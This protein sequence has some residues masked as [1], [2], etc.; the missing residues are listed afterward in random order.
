MGSGLAIRP[1]ATIGAIVVALVGATLWFL[2]SNGRSLALSEV[3]PEI[4][5]ATFR[6]QFAHNASAQQASANVYC[7]M[8]GVSWLAQPEDPPPQVL[9]R[10]ADVTPPVTP[11]SQCSASMEKGVVDKTTGRSG[12]IFRLESVRCSGES[13][14]EVNGGYYEGNLSSSGNTYT[15][16]KR[17]GKWVV[18]KDVMNWIS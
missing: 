5:E 12:L 4:A 7:V 17:D 9:S 13:S 8:Y 11:V 16:E 14:C 10:L 3:D 18:T 15:L 2:S 1:L 6:Y